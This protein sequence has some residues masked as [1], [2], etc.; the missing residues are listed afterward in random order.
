M[1]KIGDIPRSFKIANDE[2]HVE[3]LDRVEGS[4]GDD[5]YGDYNSAKSLIRIAKTIDGV[6]LSTEKILNTFYH[7]LMHVFQ[8]YFNNE[9]DEA[10]AQS[11]ANFMRE[12]DST[13]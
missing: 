6:E 3:I 1:K 13:K 2:H 10:Q 11:F 9:T 8:F 7:E 4:D 5:I 12:F